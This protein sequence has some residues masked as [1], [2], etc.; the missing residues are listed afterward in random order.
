MVC[1]AA[2]HFLQAQELYVFTEPASNMAAHSLG[3]RLSNYLMPSAHGA[4]TSF[5]T[6]PEI[7][8]GYNKN[9]MFHASGYFS[10]MYQTGLKAE[11]ASLYTKYRFYSKDDI[12]AHFRMAAFG[13][14]AVIGNPPTQAHTT[15][16]TYTDAQGNTMWYPET[17][18]IRNN[19][20]ALDGNHSGYQL[21]L[22]ATQLKNKLAVSA[23]ASYINRLNNPGYDNFETIDARH[24]VNFSASAGYL[25]FPK[26]Y[27][28][29]G[30][31]NVNL[32]VEMLGSKP[33]DGAS[34][35]L[36]AAPAVQFIFNSIA[37]VDIGYRFRIA[38]NASRMNNQ[39]FLV[40]LEYNW[41][42][43]FQSK[44]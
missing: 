9:W 34:Y 42:N 27:V 29:Y 21:G 17:K 3:F 14:I 4:K 20:L 8:W 1:S 43:A 32:Y 5:R 19:D 28:D 22:V 37:R 18:Q 10:N 23:S 36:D 41:L 31:T 6:D 15:M 7:M 16:H 40:R 2:A 35:M 33:I 12:H 38:G 26:N 39:A 30:Q 11:G 24:A 13:K 25:L 44:N